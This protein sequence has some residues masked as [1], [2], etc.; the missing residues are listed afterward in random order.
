MNAGKAG[1]RNWRGITL[2]DRN[3]KNKRKKK[4][5]ERKTRSREREIMELGDGRGWKQEVDTVCEVSEKEMTNIWLLHGHILNVGIEPGE[6]HGRTSII[7]KASSPSP[8]KAITSLLGE[9]RSDVCLTQQGVCTV[10][11]CVK[12]RWKER[13]LKKKNI[14]ERK[15][16][17]SNM[18]ACLSSLVMCQRR[19]LTENNWISFWSA[20]EKKKKK[21]L[22]SP[23]SSCYRY[24]KGREMTLSWEEF[25]WSTKLSQRNR[26]LLLTNKRRPWLP[27]E[28]SLSPPSDTTHSFWIPGISSEAGAGNSSHP[29]FILCFKCACIVK[30]TGR[31]WWSI[32]K[33]FICSSAPVG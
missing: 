5:S 17:K 16:L 29:S 12:L 11:V 7:V 22:P 27:H 8:L 4:H 28:E 21:S 23:W 13:I 20:G 33:A 6:V 2:K 18:N 10:D 32:I 3:L 14:F 24:H 15:R 26:N 19:E 25:I 1:E 9:E 30:S 31:P